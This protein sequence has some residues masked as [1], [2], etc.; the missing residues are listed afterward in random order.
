M[1]DA[2]DRVSDLLDVTRQSTP[3]YELFHIDGPIV[4]TNISKTEAEQLARE[5]NKGSDKKRFQIRAVNQ[6]IPIWDTVSAH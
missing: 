6:I 4:A 2:L 5:M 3:K 1:S